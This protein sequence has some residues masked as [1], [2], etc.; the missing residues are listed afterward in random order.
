MHGGD[1]HLADK[2]RRLIAYLGVGFAASV[3]AEFVISF[4]EASGVRSSGSG[5]EILIRQVTQ[6]LIAIACGLLMLGSFALLVRRQSARRM[7][8]CASVML[9]AATV[10]LLALQVSYANR[11]SPMRIPWQV[12]IRQADN[13]IVR[14]DALPL[15]LL[16][17]V[18]WPELVPQPSGRTDRIPE[19]NGGAE[20]SSLATRLVRVLSV[21]ALVFGGTSLAILV[22]LVTTHSMGL[23]DLRPPVSAADALQQLASVLEWLSGILMIVGAAGELLGRKWGRHFLLI[24]AVLWLVGTLCSFAWSVLID[25]T[26]TRAIRTMYAQMSD[27]VLMLLGKLEQC[28]YPVMLLVCLSWREMRVSRNDEKPTGFPPIMSQ[29][30]DDAQADRSQSS[31]ED[32]I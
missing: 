11:G 20:R 15:L 1:T 4:M 18:G 2:L 27:D 32:L 16:A 5:T 13:W 17:F 26:T 6:A 22:Y 21:Y 8:L 25:A 12:V 3:A 7:L 14:T 23:P 31:P 29:S 28:V 10:G 30:P 19:H 24:A 9:L